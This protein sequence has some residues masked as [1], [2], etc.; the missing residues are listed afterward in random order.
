MWAAPGIG[1]GFPRGARAG[2]TGEEGFPGVAYGQVVGKGV[3]VG[4]GPRVFAGEI[5]L[6]AAEAGEDF[7]AF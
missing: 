7:L 6:D 3:G 4:V 5:H 1:D 2:G